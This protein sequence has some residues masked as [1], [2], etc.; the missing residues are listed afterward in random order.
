VRSQESIA[1][2]IRAL[3]SKTVARGATP[4]EAASAAA[5]AQELLNK[6]NLDMAAVERETGRQRDDYGRFDFAS[7]IAK[8]DL[9]WASELLAGV[10]RN[11]FCYPILM[12]DGQTDTFVLVGRPEN[13]EVAEYMLRYLITE[14][15]RLRRDAWRTQGKY[16]GE[17]QPQWRKHFGLGAVRTINRMLREQRERDRQ[18]TPGTMALI[19]QSDAELLAAKDR[20]FGETRSRRA[21]RVGVTSGYMT[22]QREGAKV[23]MRPGVRTTS[24]GT[25][26]R[27][28]GP[29]Q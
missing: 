1:E 19:T 20:L 15:L 9:Q 10:A 27:Q 3:L 5:K 28:L 2:L 11:N 21:S 24:T 22:G 7:G 13:V 18:S 6:Y 16:S 23:Q 17:H 26:L 25:V 12:N 4:E 8:A 14:I 29:G